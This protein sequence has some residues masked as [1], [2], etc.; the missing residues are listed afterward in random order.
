MNFDQLVIER[1]S[2][3]RY[4]DRPVE[5]EKIEAILE[6]CR[7]APSACNSQP[8]KFVMVTDRALSLEVAKATFSPMLQFNRFAVLAPV[9]AVLVM[10]PAKML[11]K[12]GSTVKDK[13][14]SM[15]DTGIVASHFCLQAAE[16]GLGTCMLGWFDEKKVRK[17]LNIPR[18]KRIPLIITLG[19][20]VDEKKRRKIR[21]RPDEMA[22]FNQY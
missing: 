16:L 6:A 13:D 5:A 7:L 21:K 15:I 22:S 3:R 8:W 4:A 11:S 18:T 17:L 12:I 19:Y 2:T 9:M 1:E 14:L 10:E 20:P